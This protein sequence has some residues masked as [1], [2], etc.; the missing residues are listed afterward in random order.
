MREEKRS[1]IIQD[2]LN[3]LD[4]EMIKDVETLRG[5]VELEENNEFN[6]TIPAKTLI[7]IGRLLENEK[8]VEIKVSSNKIVFITSKFPVMDFFIKLY[9]RLPLNSP[10]RMY[11]LKEPRTETGA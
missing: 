8:E 10:P 6:A 5:K 11:L 4:D 2:A 7:E 3:F 9:L 1:E